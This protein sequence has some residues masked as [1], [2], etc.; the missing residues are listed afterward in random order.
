MAIEMLKVASAP[1]MNQDQCG[2]IIII[3]FIIN[4]HVN[5]TPEKLCAHVEI[6]PF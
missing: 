1:M 5:G 2:F 3:V 4:N 6:F